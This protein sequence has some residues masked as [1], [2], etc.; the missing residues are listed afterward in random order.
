MEYGGQPLHRRKSVALVTGGALAAIFFVALGIFL[1][2][3]VLG[4]NDKRSNVVVAPSTTATESATATTTPAASTATMSPSVPTAVIATPARAVTRVAVEPTVAP[5]AKP[6]TNDPAITIRG[7]RPPVGTEITQNSVSISVDVDYEAGPVS[8]VLGWTIYY[9]FGPGDCNTYGLP[10]AYDIQPGTAGTATLEG[11][12]TSDSSVT[13]PATICRL[14]VVIGHFVT[15]EVQWDSGTADRPACQTRYPT[16]RVLDVQPALNSPLQAGSTVSV[17]LQYDAS[18]IT[19][20]PSSPPQ[21]LPQLRVSY[22][23]DSCAAE[24]AVTYAELTPGATGTITIK[25]P[26]APVY[27]GKKLWH[28][29]ARIIRGDTTLAAY[30]FG[31]C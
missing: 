13:R 11:V 20:L 21:L 31:P 17:N 6:S 12:F 19:T 27:A 1:G 9:C 30:A 29:S 26:V 7:I 16:I 4:E 18:P 15:P 3:S 28:I 5:T 14:S 23:A 25:I 22:Y 24:A 2:R 8:N 10:T